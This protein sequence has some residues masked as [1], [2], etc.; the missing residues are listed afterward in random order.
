MTEKMKK[1]INLNDKEYNMNYSPLRYPGGKNKLY[2][3]VKLMINKNSCDTIYIEPFV[4]G[5]GLSLA[6]LYNKDIKKIVINDY[7]KAIYSVW[8]AILTETDKFI[9]LINNTPVTIE[10]WH[11]QK[12]IYLNKNKKYSLELGFATFFLNRTNRSGVLKA[13]PIGGYS[14]KGVYKIDCRY[15]KEQL[16]KKIMKIANNK[17][18]IKLYNYDVRTFIKKIIPL[19]KNAF[20]YFDPPYFNKGKDLYKNFF[21]KQDHEDIAA[22]IKKVKGN[23][24]VT[25]DN[26]ETIK[27]IYKEYDIKKYKV[28][29]SLANTGEAEELIFISNP[30]LWPSREDLETIKFKIESLTGG[31]K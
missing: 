12:S 19:Y 26:S 17:S 24:M 7:D 25:Y 27:E 18:K 9:N 5:G 4:G 3:L 6:L 29:Y 2:P 23:W 10:E 1:I 16:I 8:R 21:N 11:R 13:G 22:L 31:E 14:Q 28:I 30:L 15:N 20:I